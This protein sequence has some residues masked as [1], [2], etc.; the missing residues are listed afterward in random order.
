MGKWLTGS[1]IER[2]K[3]PLP[4]CGYL[5]HRLKT[6]NHSEPYLI[7]GVGSCFRF[8]SSMSSAAARTYTH[9]HHES[10]KKSHL[11]ADDAR[12]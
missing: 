10:L 1:V 7:I 12:P 11:Q 6:Q 8:L 9:P 4:L 3:T 5:V 2:F